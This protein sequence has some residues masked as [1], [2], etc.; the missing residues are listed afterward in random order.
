MSLSRRVILLKKRFLLCLVVCLSVVIGGY[1]LLCGQ[2]GL[3]PVVHYP[4]DLPE[5]D[6][7]PGD[8]PPAGEYFLEPGYRLELVADHLTY[9]TMVTF[10]DNGEIYV[11][12][13]GYSYGAA[14][15]IP[16][17]LQV[18]EDGSTKEIAR[19][20][21]GPVTSIHH[22]NG[23]VYAIGGRDPA[24]VWRVNPQTGEVQTVL[25]GFPVWG[26]HFTSELIFGPDGKMYFGIGTPS[27]SGVLGL[28]D[29][30]SF[31]YLSIFP[32]TRDI[33][34][35]DLVLVGQNFITDNPF[36]PDPNDKALTGAFK[37]FGEPSRPG[38]V[39]KAG[40][41]PEVNG[42]VFRANSD[43]S[44]L[45]V[46]ASGFRN[47][48]GMG[49]SPDGRLFGIDQGMD[50]SGSRPVANDF[51]PLWLIK[52]GGWYGFPDYP[53]GIPITD[54][55]FDPKERE[56]PQ[57]LLAEHP[58]LAEGPFFRFANS[59]GSHH[60]DFSRNPEFGFVGDMF[61][62]QYGSQFVHPP[63][64]HKVVRLNLET[65]KASDFYVNKV[66]GPEGVAPERPTAAHFGPDGR[67][68]V[69]D[70]GELAT[71]RAVFFPS[72]ATGSLWRISRGGSSPSPGFNYPLLFKTLI[73]V[74]AL[75]VGVITVKAYYL[76][77]V[78]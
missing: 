7:K 19:L 49:F 62:A 38:E 28:D 12:E 17:I 55:L 45:E 46:F 8:S 22:H 65:K 1:F 14:T 76:S 53:S 71:D 26:H 37:R 64:G 69:V 33:P 32:E 11:S 57:F 52:K 2:N 15:A 63:R 74:V 27:N 3:F 36:T 13:A 39:I 68:Y 56:A 24:E 72:A 34:G 5:A 31:G 6:I 77:K 25:T 10:G 9:P 75:L 40:I 47:I 54:P 66:P 78:R 20:P 4:K 18:F 16:R 50:N 30:H 35:V 73:V 70:F 43:G 58:P 42:V 21:D 59:T 60:F 67:L 44:Q 51:D 23:A 41:P 48:Y 61:T 29:Y